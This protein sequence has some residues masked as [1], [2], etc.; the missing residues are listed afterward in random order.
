MEQSEN[1]RFKY[2]KSPL[3]NVICQLRFPTILIIETR[4]PSDF[5]EAIRERFPFYEKTIEYQQNIN[6]FADNPIN[7]QTTLESNFNHVF[8]SLNKK[9]KI[10]LTK[11]FISLSTDEYSTWEEF[12]EE[13]RFILERFKTVYK[14]AVYNRTGLRYVDVFERSE[15]GF[16]KDKKWNELISKEFLGY[17]SNANYE[18]TAQSFNVVNELKCSDGKSL[19]RVSSGTVKNQKSDEECISLDNDCYNT[20]EV[21]VGEV[22][23]LLNTLHSNSK[24]LL[25]KAI[26]DEMHLKLEPVILD[27]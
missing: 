21:Q 26:T 3:K 1:S 4:E 9:W 8:H 12:S 10:N 20:Y 6:V 25:R 22:F 19:M 23:N 16:P 15:I 11:T 27:E 2:N 5:Q 14:P 7:S 18:D 24:S 17:Y 13:L